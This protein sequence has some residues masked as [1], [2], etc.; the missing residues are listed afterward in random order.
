M[1]NA[2]R[3]DDQPL[4]STQL[5]ALAVA[6]MLILFAQTFSAEWPA[7]VADS[8]GY[9]RLGVDLLDLGVITDRFEIDAAYGE[10]SMLFAPLYV[11]FLA[12]IAGLDPELLAYFRCVDVSTG[13]DPC[14]GVSALW[15]VVAAQSLLA[16][17]SSLFVFLSA[18]RVAGSR[19]VG[20]GAWA[21][22]L[23]SGVFAKHAS[24]VLTE[25]LTFCLFM[26]ACHFALAAAQASAGRS[27]LGWI[28]AFGAAMGATALSRPSYAYL[29]YAVVVALPFI[30]V[31]SVGL[32][33]SVGAVSALRVG[34]GWSAAFAVGFVAVAGV[35]I[36][37]NA[38]LIGT[39]AISSGYG[40]WVLAQRVAYN[41][42]TWSEFGVAFV[43]WLPDF[44]DDLARG[45][46]GA[47]SYA[48]L[49]WYDPG[50][51]Y[52]VGNTEIWIAIR[53]GY[54]P[55]ARMAALLDAYFWPQLD[56]HVITTFPLAWRAMWAGGYFALVAVIVS[57]WALW[58]LARADKLG[59][60][61][62]YA[63]P[64]AFMLGF[65]AFVSVSIVRYNESLIAPYAMLLSIA[66]IAMVRMVLRRAPSPRI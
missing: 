20:F 19:L 22:A 43:Y 1:S 11:V 38:V 15:P 14:G 39:P 56:A 6:T 30:A 51:F 57:P 3:Y 25:A 13:A 4:S 47:D 50:T 2:M 63:A 66:L 64:M 34:G 8:I 16:A 53:D 28:A 26:A 24:V 60:F 10:P 46:F 36:L 42:M 21:L 54:P 17:G 37:R 49:R 65:H 9:L 23:A 32:R 44:G 55:E 18:R 27:R 35:W 41:D 62:A 29:A 48:R 61:L 7:P 45:L 58:R 40:E 31:A 33:R 5:A 52:V 59:G 12:A